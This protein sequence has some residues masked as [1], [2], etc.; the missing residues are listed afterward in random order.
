MDL[1]LGVLL[2]CVKFDT[3]VTHSTLYVTHLFI[4]LWA[5]LLSADFRLIGTYPLLPPGG[6]S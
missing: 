4:H 3:L 1:I 6:H 2:V 5:P